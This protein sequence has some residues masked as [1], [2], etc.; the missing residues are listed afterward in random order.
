[1]KKIVLSAL[2]L[3]L[4]ASAFAQPI[5]NNEIAVS[6]GFSTANVTS[7]IV[8]LTAI[9]FN[10]L[11]DQPTTSEDLPLKSTGSFSVEYF[12]RLS[13]LVSIGGAVTY[14]HATSTLSSDTPGQAAVKNVFGILPAVKL[15][16]YQREW[17]SAYS[18][19]GAGVQFGQIDSEKKARFSAQAS[20]LGLEVGR[21]IRFFSEAGAGQQGILLAGLRVRF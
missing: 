8:N 2:V 4:A 5:R 10:S 7:G 9:I 14:Y 18:K 20:L 3:L 1:M 13:D 21:T 15:H 19:F 17:F 16:W 11:V 12:H 6:Y